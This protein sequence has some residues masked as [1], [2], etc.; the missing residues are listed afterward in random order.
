MKRSVTQRSPR[1]RV[2]ATER[3]VS[4]AS[5]HDSLL[6]ATGG[7]PT[8]LIFL[9]GPPGSGKSA[10]GRRACADL[11]IEFLDLDAPVSTPTVDSLHSDLDRLTGVVSDRAA[12]VIELPWELQ[13]E[14]KAL[15]LARKSGVP[16]LLWAH[17]EDMQVRS[18]RG[19]PL[20][21]PV[22]RLEQRGG[23][24]R[25]GTGCREFRRLDRACDQTLLLVDLPLDEAAAVVRDCIAE[26]REE[27]RASPAEREGL[28]G[29]IEDWRQDHDASARV[30]HVMVD[31][32]AR[33]LAHLR[34]S[35]HSPRARSAV[36]SDLNAAGHLVLMYD[37][38]KGT[39][40]LT[41][42]HHPPW[43][44]E[45]MRKFTDSPALVARYR[46]SL[47]GFA[48]FLTEFDQSRTESMHRDHDER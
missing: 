1:P 45:F 46:R 10:L 9:L 47:Q 43:E 35:G 2:A 7:G 15:I 23:F 18:G 16:L 36:R 6:P 4:T 29:W 8:P 32:M 41:H 14:R 25:N 39:C 34:A 19:D 28:D 5:A 27:S 48:R 26:I 11:G 30:T 17:P 12:D 31:A 40:I 3:S 22:P 20:F 42:F 37:E 13:H 21:T 38:P 24:G 33:Y 44:F